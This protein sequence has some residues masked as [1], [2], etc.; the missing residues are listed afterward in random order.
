[1]KKISSPH[2]L[3]ILIKL[4]KHG[5]SYSLKHDPKSISK[6]T[7]FANSRVSPTENFSKK[8]AGCYSNQQYLGLNEVSWMDW[9]NNLL[10]LQR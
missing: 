4:S 7:F 8:T 5:L 3:K 9:L 2:Y 6:I 1:M 10:I